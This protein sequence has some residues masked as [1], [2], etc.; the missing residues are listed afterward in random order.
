MDFEGVVGRA[1]VDQAGVVARLLHDFNAEFDVPTPGVAVLEE[2][3]RILL[4][5]G[6]AVGGTT[7]YL[8]E[9]PDG[10]AVGVALVTWHS[11]VWYD[12]AV[13]L[14]D[15]LYVVPAR[16]GGGVGSALLAQVLQDARHLGAGSVE[17]AADEPDADALRFYR[18]HGFVGAFERDERTF[19]L[20]REL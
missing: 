11:N 14:L 16:R 4:A 3:L 12:G 19:F 15:E 2:R 1:G 8:A 10:S 18:R 13:G 7:A 20:Q 9:G 17:L 6:P 5:V